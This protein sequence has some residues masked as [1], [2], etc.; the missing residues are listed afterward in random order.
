MYKSFLNIWLPNLLAGSFIGIISSFW[1]ISV[2]ALLFS[3]RLMQFLGDG[4]TMMLM[5]Q[6]VMCLFIAFYSPLKGEMA[7]IQ[8]SPAIVV[9]VIINNIISSNPNISDHEL[10]ILATSAIIITT[11]ITGISFILLGHFKLGELVRYIPYP[12]IAGFLAGAGWLAAQGGVDFLLG[13][14]TQSYFEVLSS[15]SQK[16]K[17]LSGVGFG[18]VLFY[19]LNR[20]S[21]F[22]VLPCILTVAISVFY[23]AL[24]INAISI[25]EIAT[26]GWLLGPFPEL[27]S[28]NLAIFNLADVDWHILIQQFNA[29]VST[30][31]LVSVVC[32]LLNV[33][34]IEL[35]FKTDIDLNKSLK[36]TGIANV[37]G[38]LCG[39]G[40]GFCSVSD[41]SLGYKIKASRALSLVVSVI[42]LFLLYA[43]LPILNYLPGFIISG[44][45]IYVGIDFLYNWVYK[46]YSK[47]NKKEY[48]IVL[49]VMLTIVI[50]GLIQGLITGIIIALILFVIDFSGISIIKDSLSGKELQSNNQRGAI[51][52]KILI[53]NGDGIKIFI[54]TGF[55]FF[56]TANKL[57]IKIKEQANSTESLTLKYIIFD[58]RQVTGMDSS[59]VYSLQKILQLSDIN[60]I[61]LI[62]TNIPDKIKIVLDKNFLEHKSLHIFPSLNN[63]LE[64]YENKVLL[65]FQKDVRLVTFEKF[66]LSSDI[67]PDCIGTLLGYFERKHIPEDYYLIRQG[68]AAEKLYFIES[69]LLDVF[70]EL[71]AEK[72]VYL[73]RINTGIFVG[74]IGL[75]LKQPRSAS[76]MT[77]KPSV[78]YEL[79]LD[80]LNLMKKHSIEVYAEFEQM[81]ISFLAKR[82]LIANARFKRFL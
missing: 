52:Q 25:A 74:E 62:F 32:L 57:F 1:A 72:R 64:W 37:L 21:G 71:D 48:V 16:L 59:T 9:M 23:I 46:I 4:I 13:R 28:K 27:I 6:L 82:L 66:L 41:S 63:G 65:S 30:L 42:P 51:E 19:A 44:L 17:L 22:L 36:V 47:I 56:G 49:L 5:G 75:L 8:T 11:L 29:N 26:Q 15:S 68:D 60:N 7:C 70:F 76:V 33:T 61:E 80:N 50:N 18:F 78:V 34:A 69:G 53:E 3:D 54:L 38:S 31:V 79:S 39:S 14:D 35:I 77:S 40:V 45:L 58:W 12:I 20:Y 10:F 67:K 2:A 43:G 24:L 81:M 73:E 55:I